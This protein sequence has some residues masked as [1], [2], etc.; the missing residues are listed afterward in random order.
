MAEINYDEIKTE[1]ISSDVSFSSLAR[2]YGVSVS[3]ISRR[4]K[5]QNWDKEKANISKEVQRK[6]E[7]STIDARTSIAQNCI[8]ALTILAEKIVRNA[9]LL[10]DDDIAGK[11]ALSGVL[12]DMRDM[13]AFEL[14]EASNENTITIKFADEVDE[15]G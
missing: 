6:V 8:K 14:A 1:Y 3:A 12:K 10:T 7:E 2:K 9:E 15:Y 4:A 13:G 5:K 11:K